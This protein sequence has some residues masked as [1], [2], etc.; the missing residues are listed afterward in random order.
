MDVVLLDILHDPVD[1]A[2]AL[3][4]ALEEQIDAA[5]DLVLIGLEDL[6]GRKEHGGMAVVAAHMGNAGNLG[7]ADLGLLGIDGQFLNGQGVAVGTQQNGLAGSGAVEGGQ[8]AAV[9]DVDIFD[10]DLIQLAA[11]QL[12]GVELTARQL[13]V[14][15]QMAA[16]RS[17]VL[18][19]SQAFF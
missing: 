3:F 2:A 7:N 4:T 9:G 11:D 12:D 15:V 8:N 14:L 5:L 19:Q 16:D 17:G 6:S 13:G 1:V 10:A 18:G